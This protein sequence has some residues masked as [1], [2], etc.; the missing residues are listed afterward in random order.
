MKIP[1][2]TGK[3]IHWDV[4]MPAKKIYLSSVAGHGTGEKNARIRIWTS[5]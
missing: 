4:E 2:G 3:S 5:V 1:N